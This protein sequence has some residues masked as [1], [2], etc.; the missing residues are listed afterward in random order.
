MK[1]LNYD[2]M[3]RCKAH[4]AGSASARDNRHKAVQLMAN[5]LHTL[6]YKLPLASSLKPKHIEVLIN[7]W[8][9]AGITDG[10]IANRL[11]HLRWWANTVGKQGI[12]APNNKAYGLSPRTKGT[13]NRAQ[14]LT[15]TILNKITCPHVQASLRLMAAFG[16][17]REEA[18]KLCPSTG[19]QGGYVVL[20]GS[21]CKGGRPRQVPVRTDAQRAALDVAISVA[22][23]GSLIPTGKRYVQHMK[24]FE[25]QTMAAGLGNTHA[26]R[27]GYAQ[28]RYA[29]LTGWACPLAGGPA[30]ASLNRGQKDIDRRARLLIS[31]E[32]GHARIEI[33]NAYLGPRR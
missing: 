7:H 24:A 23:K 29:H 4:N 1:N 8:R 17:R 32:L 18:M 20:K 14:E 26:L 12:V 16:L 21:W 25:Y 13:V 31:Q 27:H 10:T 19:L 3:K 6:G 30:Y 15:D 9:D 22:G 11:A 2:L 33:T 28:N 5:Q